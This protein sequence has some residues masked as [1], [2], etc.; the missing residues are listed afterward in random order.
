MSSKPKI[1]WF[2]YALLAVSSFSL[3]CPAPARAR[4]DPTGLGEPNYLAS[5][6]ASALTGP[7][8]NVYVSVR[9][10]TGLPVNTAA[11]VK[12]SC[13]LAGVD[14]RGA[15]QGTNAQFQFKNV[16]VGDCNIEVSAAGYKTARDRTEVMQS[17]TSRNQYVFIYL[18]PESES[19]ELAAPPPAVPLGPIKEM[20]KAMEAIQTKHEADERKHLDKAARISPTNPDVAYLQGMMELHQHNFTS[21]T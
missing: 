11:L 16:P 12:L 9:E 20:D 3:S 5:G 15:T 8:A 21:A 13:P 19:A 2:T 17:Y 14:V 1:Q 6:F 4:D 18:H 10:S 7:S